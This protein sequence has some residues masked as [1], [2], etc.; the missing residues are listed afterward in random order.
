MNGGLSDFILSPFPKVK[1]LSD[2]MGPDGSSYSHLASLGIV[3]VISDPLLAGYI[4]AT[5]RVQHTVY[6]YF[7]KKKCVYAQ[8]STGRM[9]RVISQRF[10][11]CPVQY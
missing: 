10:I 4:R 1:T 3:Y 11:S 7:K 6:I 8:K 5:A 9:G 2:S